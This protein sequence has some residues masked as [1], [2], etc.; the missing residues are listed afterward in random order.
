MKLGEIWDYLMR[1]KLLLLLVLGVSFLG[2][3][4]CCRL[5]TTE[6]HQT[7]KAQNIDYFGSELIRFDNGLVMQILGQDD[8]PSYQL[9]L[10]D[11]FTHAT[12][13]V[14]TSSLTSEAYVRIFDLHGNLLA[15]EYTE[16][17]ATSADKVT[18]ELEYTFL[19]TPKSYQLELEPGCMIEVRA[20]NVYFYSTLNKQA[21][22]AFLPQ[23]TTERYVVVDGGLRKIDWSIA[24]GKRQ[25]YN[26]LRSFALNLI[27]NYEQTVADDVVNNKF[28]DTSS[29]AQVVAAYQALNPSDQTP[30][31]DFIDRLIKGGV[32]QITYLGEN[33]YLVDS[34]VSLERLISVFDNED[35][36]IPAANIKIET[37]L[38]TSQPGEYSVTVTA[39][40]QDHNIGSSTV[41]IRIVA[42][43]QNNTEVFL[44]IDGID[45]NLNQEL[46]YGNAPSN[47]SQS[48][49]N[50]SS[51]PNSV[52]LNNE[53]VELPESGT[54]NNTDIS[55]NGEPEASTSVNG[56]YNMPTSSENQ[57][58]Q[59]DD[60]ST[61][62]SQ[63]TI[64]NFI[65][66]GAG[67]V[68]VL[69]FIRFIFDHYVR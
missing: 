32:P 9:E 27:E 48:V 26:L 42:K 7:F 53:I 40:D 39:E 2:G 60:K 64:W 28:L 61:T 55:T 23:Q 29:K 20:Q 25:T 50:N 37:N 16:I 54:V 69:L 21:A 57:P 1:R 6:Q 10:S 38:D 65:L 34:Q 17:R 56:Y 11:N 62:T 15:G 46:D 5:M 24:E 31:T 51:L 36:E 41:Y 47:P 12:V 19:D 45:D 14:A 59:T 43:N 3:I 66:I 33:E 67:I 13:T 68:I 35:G 30:Y 22:L 18:D 49:T 4:L 63:P 44:P 52:G 8:I 58:D